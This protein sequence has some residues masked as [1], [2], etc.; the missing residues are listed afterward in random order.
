MV[1]CEGDKC[2]FLFKFRDREA[3][4][5]FLAGDFNDWNERSHPMQ[6]TGEVWSLTLELPPGEHRFKYLVDG[7]WHNDLEAHKYVPNV[8]GSDD[9]VVVVPGPALDMRKEPSDNRPDSRIG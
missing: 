3:K 8:W 7:F 1:R 9:S 2:S 5:V 4:Q 6:K